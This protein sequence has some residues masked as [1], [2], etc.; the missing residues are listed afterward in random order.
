MIK[1]VYFDVGGVALKDFSKT[2]KWQI[3]KRDLGIPT[4]LD[5]DFDQYFNQIEV[6]INL[7]HQIETYIPEIN[8]KFRT[9]IALDFDLTGMFVDRFEINE[10]IYPLVD[11]VRQTCGI[12][13][14][15]N[16]YPAM[17]ELSFARGLIPNLHWDHI[18]NS[19]K[20]AARKPEEKIYQIA[21]QVTGF[22]PN[23]ILFI[24]NT[25]ENIDMAVKLGWQGYHYDPTDYDLA[26]QNLHEYLRLA[27]PGL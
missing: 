24:D 11:M 21:Q 22:S 2:N 5:S 27:L 18:I 4:D 9:K 15:T 17:L 13:L 3:F 16:M 8:Q 7:G 20:V 12:G 10:G 6:E 14:L 19:C 23:E 25:Q 1:F 26:N